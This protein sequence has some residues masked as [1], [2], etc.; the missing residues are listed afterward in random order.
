MKKFL[1]LSAEE[2]LGVARNAFGGEFGKVC[3]AI[4]FIGENDELFK[5]IEDELSIVG[6]KS[7]KDL[8]S[9]TNVLV[10]YEKDRIWLAVCSGNSDGE[11][12]GPTIAAFY[13][14][15]GAAKDFRGF[16]AEAKRLGEG[17]EVDD[18]DEAELNDKT[19]MVDCSVYDEGFYN[20][21]H[22]DISLVF[23]EP[24]LPWEV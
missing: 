15:E 18:Y 22:T 5:K 16:V 14:K 24:K 12:F 17:F 13:G 8:D 4:K 6:I 19:S 21:D 9:E 1:C 11:P 10:E 3:E 7:I 2:F 23:V 20:E